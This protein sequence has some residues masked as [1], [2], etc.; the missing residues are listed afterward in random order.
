MINW[1]KFRGYQCG[2]YNIDGGY[3]GW[4][5]RVTYSGDLP[6]GEPWGGVGRNI[7]GVG[8]Q[9]ILSKKPDLVPQPQSEPCVSHQAGG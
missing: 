2:A 7:K 9:R 5:T 8:S 1:R 4:D 6:R 3:R